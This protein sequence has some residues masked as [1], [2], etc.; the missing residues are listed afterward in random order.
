LGPLSLVCITF[1]LF[2]CKISDSGSRKPRL[3]AAGSVALTDKRWSLGRYSWLADS[4]YE[5]YYCGLREMGCSDYCRYVFMVSYGI[6]V[7]YLLLLYSLGT[8]LFSSEVILAGSICT[9]IYRIL[10]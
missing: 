3:T 4:N 9:V 5:Y 1:V 8:V 7:I 10:L 6:Y 2:E